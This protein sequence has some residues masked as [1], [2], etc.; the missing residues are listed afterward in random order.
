MKLRTGKKNNLK[1]LIKNLGTTSI[2][3]AIGVLVGILLDATV[4]AIFGVGYETDAFFAAF[5]IPIIVCNAIEVQTPKVLVPELSNFNETDH[6]FQKWEH[7][8]NIINLGMIIF[9]L[10]SLI[11]FI[12]SPIIIPLQIIGASDNTIQLSILLNKI[13]FWII[14]LRG[15]NNILVSALYSIHNYFL[16]AMQ[17]V[18]LNTVAMLT[19]YV[20]YPKF[21]IVSLALG[22]VLGSVFNMVVMI[23]YLFQ[24]GFRYRFSSRFKEAHYKGVLKNC[25]YPFAGHW[26]SESRMIIENIIASF[27]GSGSLTIL[28]YSG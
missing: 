5:T 8:C 15:L 6:G 14:A 28:R 20:L 13:L 11:G 17:K 24:K 3:R 16:P 21:G 1:Y 18:I 9:L 10:L 27:I 23:S 19:C 4:V 7:L 25:V 2:L 26:I 12:I 22:H